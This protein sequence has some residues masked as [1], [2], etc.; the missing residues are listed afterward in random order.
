MLIVWK[1]QQKIIEEDAQ[2]K[3]KIGDDIWLR[4]PSGWIAGIYQGNVYV[5]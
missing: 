4:I 2:I 3:Q 5:R 1:V